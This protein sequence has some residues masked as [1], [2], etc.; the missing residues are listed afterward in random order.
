V[1]N[2]PKDCYADG[3]RAKEYRAWRCENITRLV[4]AVH[5]GV[6][7]IKPE[8]KVSAAVFGLYP[9]CKKSIGQDWVL[10][11]QSGYVDF[12]CPMNYTDDEKWFKGIVARQMKQVDGKV[13]LCPGIGASSA[14]T[15]LSAEQVTSQITI[16]EQLG[17]GGFT[18]FNLSAKEAKRLL[19]GLKTGQKP[20][21]KK[22]R[23]V[24]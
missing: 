16:T 9:S 3:P 11:A 21:T 5:D 8:V 13:P 10:W 23:F 15:P 24:D 1:E 7:K 12:L 17:T 20:S 22:N 2:W 18:I 19:P 6:Q 14:K 4:K